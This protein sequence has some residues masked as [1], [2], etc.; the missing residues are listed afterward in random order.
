[1]LIGYKS[2]YTVNGY[3]G[4]HN[5]DSFRSDYREKFGKKPYVSPSHG[6]RWQVYMSPSVPDSLIVLLGREVLNGRKSSGIKVWRRSRSSRG[7]GL[8]TFGRRV[9]MES[10]PL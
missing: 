4:Y 7:G 3:Y 10:I 2:A 5:F 8:N 6:A 9:M 1:M